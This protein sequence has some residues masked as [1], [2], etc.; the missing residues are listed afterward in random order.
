MNRFYEEF[1]RIYGYRPTEDELEDFK[2]E[3]GYDAYSDYDTAYRYRPSNAS[4]RPSYDASDA[5]VASDVGYEFSALFRDILG[6]AKS[7][8]RPK[9]NND[10]E[11]MT[12]FAFMLL[13]F[14]IK[15]SLFFALRYA[16]DHKYCT[17]L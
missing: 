3:Q 17:S 13:V 16:D 8:K 12:E 10:N 11:L 7:H 1:S 14:M 6:Q 9:S 15:S 5:N 2:N 4:R